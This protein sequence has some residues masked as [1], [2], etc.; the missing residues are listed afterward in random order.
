MVNSPDLLN[1]IWIGAALLTQLP[2]TTVDP[3]GGAGTVVAPNAATFVFSSPQFF[4]ALISGIVLAFGFQLLLTNLSVAAGISY[5]GN[6]SKPNERL[7]NHS[8]RHS[9]QHSH[10]DNSS[11]SGN[12]IRL[13]AGLWT[14]ISVSLALFL[15]CFLAV[16]LTLIQSAL[17]GAIIGLVIWGAYFSMLVWI[18]STTVG[19]LVGSLVN[20]A[21]SGLQAI[22]GTAT[23]ALGAAATKN[24]IVSTAES[25]VAAVRRELTSG[26]DSETLRENIEEYLNKLRPPGL[27]V[28][29]VR[30]EFEKLLDDPELKAIANPEALQQVDRATL[31]NL[32]NSRTDLSKREVESL[33][34]QLE[35]AWQQAVNK[36]HKPDPLRE[37]TDYLRT[38]PAGQ[39][40]PQEL[41]QRLNGL[42]NTVG[43]GGQAGQAGQSPAASALLSGLM[44]IVL[45][46]VDLS[47]LD[48]GQMVEQIKSTPLGEK[49]DKML[50]KETPYSVIRADVEDY[51]L[52]TYSW[53]LTPESIQ[54]D[55]RAIIYDE[56]ADASSVRREVEMLNQQEFVTLLQSRGVFVQDQITRLAQTLE[57]VRLEVLREVSEIEE[58]E[59]AYSLKTQLEDFLRSS[60]KEGLLNSQA[61]GAS[62]R[63]ILQDSS[64]AEKLRSRLLS[65]NRDFLI[66]LLNAR[67]DLTTTEVAQI[68]TEIERAFELAVAD[69][70]GVP[71][72]VQTR[73]STQWQRIEDYLRN[74]G[75]EELNPE[76]IQ[77]DLQKLVDDPQVGLARLRDRASHLDRDTL[78]KLLSQRNDLSESEINQVIDQYQSTLQNIIKA[79]R[80]LAT[81]TQ[82]KVRDFRTGLEDYLRNTQKEELSPEGIQRDLKT[83]MTDPRLGLEKLNDRLSHVDRSHLVALL[84]QRQDLSEAEANDII[85]RVLTARDQLMA[86]MQAVQHQ[87]QA[88]VERVLNRIRTYLNSLDRPEL[89]YDGIKQEVRT[90]FDDP[91]AGFESLRDRLSSFDK[92]TLI[93]LLSSRDDISKADAERVFEQIDRARSTVLQRAER[94]QQQVQNRLDDIRYQAQV[95][96]EE[97]RKA[98]AT[99]AWWLFATALTSAIVSAIRRK[100]SRFSH[101]LLIQT[102]PNSNS[103]LILNLL[104]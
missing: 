54:K 79:P 11:N 64:D 92:D 25:A 98:A 10:D 41:R 40:L 1:D 55:F 50:K 46:R 49:T 20:T 81:R 74:T 28:Q 23:A 88:T 57:Y 71:Q 61:L 101:R 35:T 24:Q 8:D 18:S 21:T 58:T 77:R 30:Q 22:V 59:K 86:Q 34:D 43:Q 102:P 90:L 48:V 95:Q 100:P 5:L 94:L 42:L 96:V 89:N 68:T 83:L 84:S 12:K 13:A 9:A 14:V 70:Q 17:L 78:V 67:N 73:V 51:L 38:V 63:P 66:D 15:A 75:K 82:S 36:M 80:R 60:P 56:F 85:E 37:V 44:G 16:K 29:S 33:A 47:D 91:Q 27:D 99:A 76:G 31:V 103:A 39:F 65:F 72:A 32:I 26:M 104:L 97:T 93:A 52:N 4:I 19:S 53:Q 6:W 7:H 2:P 87:I 62:L 45:N 69:A 3:L